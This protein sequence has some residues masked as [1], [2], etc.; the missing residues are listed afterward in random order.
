MRIEYTQEIKDI[1]L[2]AKK[3]VAIYKSWERSKTGYK[4][5]EKGAAYKNYLLILCYGNIEHVFKNLIADYFTRPGMPSRCRRF[6]EKIRERLPGSM[7]KDRLNN[8]FKEEC[9]ELWYDEIK[10]R[11][12]DINYR[13]IKNKKFSMNDTY[14]ALTSLTNARHDF[15]HGE[16]P[17]TGKIDDLLLYYRKSIVWLYEIDDIIIKIG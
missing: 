1:L 13:C 4:Y 2:Q 14:V 10:R 7:S 17:Y 12:G 8:F 16:N 11:C 6:G 9:S 5:P 3:I 15:A